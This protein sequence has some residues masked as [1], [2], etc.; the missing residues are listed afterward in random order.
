V[1]LSLRNEGRKI[2]NLWSEYQPAFRFVPQARGTFQCEIP[3]WPFREARFSL[4]VYTHAGSDTLD[5]VEECATITSHDGDFFG[6]GRLA[7]A[8]EGMIFI[9]HQWTAD[10]SK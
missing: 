3:R 7:N 2:T 10:A 9:P 4:D 1:S 5:W 6:A 8:G